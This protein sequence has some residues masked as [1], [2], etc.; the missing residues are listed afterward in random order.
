MQCQMMQA[1]LICLPLGREWQQSQRLWQLERWGL[2]GALFWQKSSKK[3]ARAAP[4]RG[5]RALR[6]E[7]KWL[8][9]PR[10][11]LFLEGNG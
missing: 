4:G 2:S 7:E 3:G 1:A 11:R 5:F 8:I 9:A 10:S 6:W